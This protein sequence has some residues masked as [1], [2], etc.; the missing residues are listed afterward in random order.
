MKNIR[1][2]ETTAAMD[3]AILEDV[4]INYNVE[5][6]GMMTYPLVSNDTPKNITYY[7][8]FGGDDIIELTATEGDTFE[9]QA[10]KYNELNIFPVY[11]GIQEDNTFHGGYEDE[12]EGYFPYAWVE[13]TLLNDENDSNNRVKSYDAIQ[14]NHTYYYYE[15]IS[16]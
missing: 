13:F 7:I 14:E 15:W 9:T 8:S 2:F 16:N 5:T 10:D 3:A 6:N 11:I 1:K 12:R 4:S